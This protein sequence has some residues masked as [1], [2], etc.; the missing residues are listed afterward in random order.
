MAPYRGPINAYK[1]AGVGR[2]IR[3]LLAILLAPFFA[4]FVYQ[5]MVLL[6][7]N[8]AFFVTSFV[9]YGFLAYLVLY[10]ILSR[11]AITFLETLE[12]EFGHAAAALLSFRQV[13]KLEATPGSG[14]TTLGET[15]LP[16]GVAL[17]P[18]CLPLIL[19]PVLVLSFVIPPPIKYAIDFILGLVLAFHLVDLFRTEL[20]FRQ[21]DLQR[22][23]YLFS[24]GAI[25]TTNAILLVI[26]YGS[27]SGDCVSLLDYFALAY[28]SAVVLYEAVLEWLSVLLIG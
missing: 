20:R 22:V 23:G 12:H 7:E 21:T 8:A 25:G 5:A 15:R 27:A 14:Q 17:F 11:E 28:E 13:K 2:F 4:A 1:E 19:L 6:I 18:Y 3:F 16:V 9:T 10:L 26:V 24:F